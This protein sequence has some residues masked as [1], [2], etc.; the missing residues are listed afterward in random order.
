MSVGEELN[1]VDVGLVTRKS[2][3]SLAS[4]NIPELGECIASA[5]D[6]GVLIC[7]VQADAH[8]IAEV[9]GKLNLLCACLDVPFHTGHVSG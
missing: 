6:E 8:D 9:V 3:Y 1:G 4:S 5:G 7:G 2:L